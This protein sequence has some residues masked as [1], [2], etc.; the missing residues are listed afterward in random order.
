MQSFLEQV[1]LDLYEKYIK[2]NANIAIVLPNKRPELFIKKYLSNYTSSTILFPKVY[3]I[4]N[5]I[6]E[7]SDLV[8]VDE[9]TLTYHLFSSFKKYIKTNEN[10]DD[11]YFWGQMLLNDF[12]DIDKELVDAESIFQ[13]LSEIKEFDYIFD[14]LSPEQIKLIEQFWGTFKTKKD[15][16]NKKRFLEIWNNL[17]NIYLDFNSTLKS[18]SLAY[19]GMIYRDAVKGFTLNNLEK[20]SYDKYIF[21]GFNALNKAENKLLEFL[22]RENKAE[23]YW[24]YDE[25]YLNKGKHEA[26]FFIKENL[27]KFPN[28][29]QFNFNKLKS[30]KNVKIISVASRIGQVK[31]IDKLLSDFINEGTAISENTAIVLADESLLI[32][33]LYSL[34]EYITDLNVT[35]GFPFN[36]TV[37]YSL[38]LALISLQKNINKNNEFYYKDV[39]SILTNPLIANISVNAHQIIKK[40]DEENIIYIQKE[41][42]N[43]DEILSIIFKQADENNIYDYLTFIY[44]KILE[45][46]Q[47]QKI[48]IEFIT[49]ILKSIIKIN[50]LLLNSGIKVNTK[51]YFSIIK[52]IANSLSVPFDGD[53]LSGIQ[54]MGILETRLLD[55]ENIIIISTNE[56]VLPKTG[57]A[58]SFIPYNIRKAFGIPDIQHQDSIYAYYFYRLLQSAKNINL[59]Y[60]SA[61]TPQ[62]KEKSRF[63]TQIELENLYDIK[64]QNYSFETNTKSY[65]EI[66][67]YKDDNIIE[68]L[69]SIKRISPSAINV[70]IDCSLKFYYKYIAE[71]KEPVEITE[72]L[73]PAVFGSILH[74]VMEHIYKKYIGK[75]TLI[76]KQ[77]INKIINDNELIDSYILQA[78]SDNFFNKRKIQRENL[79]G[80][81][82]IIFEIIKKYVNQLLLIDKEYTPFSI[83]GLEEKNY[84]KLKI[85]DENFVEIGGSIDRVDLKDNI[86]RILDYKT[87]SAET[88]FSS[89]TDLFDNSV[90]KR[91]SAILQTFIY[92]EAF[93][94]NNSNYENIKPGIIQVKQVFDKNFASS[95]FLKQKRQKIPV[96]NYLNFRKDF[97]SELKQKVEEIYNKEVEFKGINDEIKCKYCPYKKLCHK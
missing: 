10:F 6:S 36:Q 59:V 2:Y 93:Y 61:V 22:K 7:F 26:N 86:V 66:T 78:F 48:E 34:P 85:S 1:T 90:T 39:K 45:K 92:S 60:N 31:L 16:V 54:I 4:N 57:A 20:L 40:I 13:N 87:G 15:S 80:R 69:K 12:D 91:S 74:Q 50:T 53:P 67:I 41:D 23:F 42:I 72:E 27:K 37:T 25:Y 11:F 19:G 84:F 46:K 33:L 79:H 94:N 55:F 51:T 76:D 35:M 77:K 44:N 83:L 8:E 63:I 18:Q 56:G 64:Y 14:Y 49:S 32:P 30:N 71:L 88:E 9:I 73:D 47:V 62:N 5:L 3:T 65:E 24:D 29:A 70:Y 82:I 17:Y 68:K 89:I 81:N 97:L 95:L 75:N 96:T 38:L 58:P 43:T 21:V 28:S 52:N